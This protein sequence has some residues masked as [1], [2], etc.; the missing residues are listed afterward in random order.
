[1]TERIISSQ[2]WDFKGQR[3]IKEMMDG[4]SM[5]PGHLLSLLLFS[6]FSRQSLS[7]VFND[8]GS[9]DIFKSQLYLQIE[10]HGPAG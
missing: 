6:A 2:F 1:L 10:P 8:I 9:S 7:H 5:L 4:L 3:P